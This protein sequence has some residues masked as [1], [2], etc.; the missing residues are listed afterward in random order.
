MIS[1]SVCGGTIFTDRPVLWDKLVY[2]WQLA[3]QER[4]YIDRQQGTCCVSCGANLRSIALADAI[5]TAVGTTLTLAELAAMPEATDLAVLEI[6]EAGTLSPV[7]RQF[8]GHI[9]AAY[10]V[11]DMHRMTYSDNTFDL[12]VHSD[13][14]EHV[15]NPIQALKECRRVLRPGGTLCFTIPTIVERLSRSRAGLSKSYHGSE[16]KSSDDLVVHTEFGADM[17]TYVLRAGFSTVSIDAVEYPA[18]LAISARKLGP[19]IQEVQPA[20]SGTLQAK[21]PGRHAQG[22]DDNERASPLYAGLAQIFRVLRNAVPGAEASMKPARVVSIHFPKAAGS[23]LKTQFV[24]LLGDKVAL[25]YTHDPLSP[26]GCEIASFPEGKKLVHGHF[27][28][29]RYETANA[30]WMTFLR[31][32]VD[33]LISI[34]SYWKTLPEAGH[35]LHARFLSEQPSILEFAKYPGIANLMSETYFGNFDMR[36]FD[37]VGFYEDRDACIPRLAKELGLPLVADV[38]ENRTVDAV[39]R[40]ELEADASVRRQLTDLL[41]HDVIFYERLQR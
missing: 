35:M 17:W 24:K 6:N 29:K 41:A 31:H 32:P 38:H 20:T 25:D 27:C 36:R 13:T 8:P 3:P 5:R 9:L 34:Y 18:A 7:L 12:V 10:P 14:L 22:Q 16:E 26:S 11:V 30:Y 37:F 23:S 28:A 2:E 19:L 4:A 40:R 21:S 1:C 39:G 15:A 33:N